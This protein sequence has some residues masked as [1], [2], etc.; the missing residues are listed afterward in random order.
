MVAVLAL[1]AAGLV[2]VG[3]VELTRRRALGARLE[4]QLHAAARAEPVP[5]PVPAAAPR[6]ELARRAPARRSVGRFA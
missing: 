3:L 4:H 5:V 6:P 2:V 1:V